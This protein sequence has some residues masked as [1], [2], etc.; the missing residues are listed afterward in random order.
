MPPVPPKLLAHLNLNLNLNLNPNRPPDPMTREWLA[1][2]IERIGLKE[3]GDDPWG[4]EHE[5][6][7]AALKSDRRTGTRRT[8]RGCAGRWSRPWMHSQ[9][10]WIEEAEAIHATTLRRSQ[11]A[12]Q[13]A[14]D[15]LRS[16][17]PTP[18][19]P[20]PMLDGL[21]DE[22]M[23]ERGG[24]WRGDAC[25]LRRSVEAEAVRGGQHR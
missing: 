17:E 24:G 12:E 8:I 16:A 18:V 15:A 19:G 4:G 22:E 2:E 7:L 13:R 10:S 14:A 20:G 5:L 9:R 6:I 1:A 21:D 25:A 11:A 23:P 3:I